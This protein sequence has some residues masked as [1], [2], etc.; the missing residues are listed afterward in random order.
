MPRIVALAKPLSQG[1][2]LGLSGVVERHTFGPA[3]EHPGAVE[4]RSGDGGCVVGARN[5]DRR[6]AGIDEEATK[7]I[8]DVF[9]NLFPGDYPVR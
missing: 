1:P 4:H 8:V 9:R 5:V 3:G 2:D 6:D 7:L